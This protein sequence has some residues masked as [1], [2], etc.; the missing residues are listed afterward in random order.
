MPRTRYDPVAI[1]L[2]WSMACLILLMI[3]MGFLMGD[4]PESFK[5]T[6][7]GLHKSIGITVLGLSVFR[8]V[9]RLLHRPPAL[10][11]MPVWER[12]L[13]HLAHWGLYGLMIGMPLSGWLMVS[14][15]QKYPTVYFGLGEVPF[16]PMPMDADLKAL[17]GFFGESHELLA[18]GAAALI[19]LHVAAALKHQ[20]V[21]RDGL[22]RR[23]WF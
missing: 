12:R 21:R 22:I 6:A 11:A 9:W 16:I 19:A 3:P 2:H 5:F 20:Y 8:L 7:Y 14:A 23:M 18:I 13:A 17:R 4:F 10:P 15:S 1:A